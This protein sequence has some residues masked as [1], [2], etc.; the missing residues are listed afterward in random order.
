MDLT[1]TTA[2]AT[3]LVADSR[4]APTR[5]A[6]A[7]NKD[8][9]DAQEGV[10]AKLIGRH[11]EK[12]DSELFGHERGAFTGALSQ[13]VGRFQLTDRGTLFLDEIGEFS[14]ELQ[15]K[16]LRA[17]Q[18]TNELNFRPIVDSISGLVFT[19]N[20]AGEVELLNRQVLEYFG[21]TPEELKGWAT[22]DAIHPDDLPRVVAAFA[23]SIESGNPYDIEQR[24]RRADGVY[25]WFHARGLPQRDVKGRIVRWYFLL[26]DIDDRKQAEEKLRRSEASLHDAQRISR[27]G[28]WRHD[29]SSGTIIVS[30][31]LNRIFGNKIDEDASTPELYFSRIHPEDGKRIQELFERSEIQKTDFQADYRLVLP[32]GTIKHV[33]SIGRPIL[34]G[35]GNLVEFVGTTT[36][37]TERKVAEELRAEKAREVALRADVSMAF[38]KINLRE[39]L[40]DCTEAMVRHLDAAFARIWTVNKAGDVLEL[41]ASSGM[42][43]NIDGTY[44]R[45]PIGELVIGRIAQQRKPYLNNDVPNDPEI[46]ES[47]WRVEGQAGVAVAGYPLIAGDRVV[48]VMAVFART[49]LTASTLD[50]LAAVADAISEAIERQRLEGEL[51][52]ERDRLRLLL[53]LNNRVASNL[54]L[55]E[56]FQA[57]SSEL[58]R[59]FE[60]DCVSLALPEP[61][62]TNLRVSNL[63]FPDGKGFAREEAVV[64]IDGS[65]SGEVFRSG[66]SL[67][68][69]SDELNR[70][71]AEIDPAMGEGYRSRCFLPVISRSLVLGTL[72][73]GRTKKQEIFTQEEIE[74]LSQVA[75]QIAI[76]LKNAL[77]YGQVTETKQ[78]LV[79]QKLYLEDE[80]RIERNFEEIIGNSPRLKDVLESVR[81]VAPAD[82]TVLIQ[83]E[84]GTGKEL[85][86][87]AIHELSP[88]KGQAFVKVNCAAIPSGLLE[89][90]LFGHE[91]GAF[92]GAIA[93]KIGRFEL[94]HKGTLFLDE[95]GDIP[96]ELQ[97]KLL[98]V[99]QEQEFERLGSIR[100]QRVDVRLLAATNAGLTQMVAEKKFRSDLYYRLNVFPINVPSLRDRRD[101]I[102]LL[103]RHF[104]NKY[105]RRIGKRIESITTETMDA[106]SR[107]A[108]PGNIRELQNLMERAVLLSKGASLRVPLGEIFTDSDPGAISGGN[109]LEQAEREQIVRALCESNWVVG[110]ARGAAARLGLKR[111]ALA[112]KMQKFGISRPPQ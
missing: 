7:P 34:N 3:H 83:G 86:A 16:L 15:R 35:Q 46:I 101:D 40:R 69:N 96:L 75:S 50:T 1:L 29:F 62:G 89:S 81:T 13:Q 87:R 94:A 18:S 6:A 14:L 73:V 98:R 45:L 90:E 74:F 58:R 104:A 21:K 60:C 68:L 82:S 106:L 37:I 12:P 91:K 67:V 97:P 61:G 88:R 2:R 10:H 41:Q 54:D 27:T 110:G 11:S 42:Y 19:L 93:Q 28:S 33:H 105:A 24:C 53:D 95:I 31:E 70:V 79:E 72:T 4:R 77:E 84:T 112:Y 36:D 85:I 57:I 100:T 43:T 108:W 92:T 38:G 55:P 51:Q 25:R 64:R 17:V 78:R 47:N 20:P 5:N 52:H 76:T 23:Y 39:M 48:G 49:V 102:P 30:P 65:P 71:S 32:D 26:T 59:V 111:T 66:K 109:A 99:L 80:I 8:N 103:V 22:S 107:Y 44:S 63:D 56:F 9:K